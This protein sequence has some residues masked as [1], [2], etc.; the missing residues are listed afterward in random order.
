[1]IFLKNNLLGPL[2]IGQIS[3]KSFLLATVFVSSGK[4]PRQRG[5]NINCPA[6]FSAKKNEPSPLLFLNVSYSWHVANMS[7]VQCTE[8]QIMLL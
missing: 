1:M 2:P 5:T 4:S 6:A 3:F 8:S 7:N